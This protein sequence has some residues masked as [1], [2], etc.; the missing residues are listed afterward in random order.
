MDDNK[1]YWPERL[2][3]WLKCTDIKQ[4]QIGGLCQVKVKAAPECASWCSPLDRLVPASW[5]NVLHNLAVCFAIKLWCRHAQKL[6]LEA[7]CYVQITSL[8]FARWG[9]WESSALCIA[10][11][12]SL[13]M[14]QY[15]KILQDG[16]SGPELSSF[17]YALGQLKNVSAV[18]ITHSSWISISA[19]WQ[20]WQW[21]T[22]IIALHHK[23]FCHALLIAETLKIVSS[24]A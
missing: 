7:L 22:V 1:I 17:V 18:R 2:E 23:A 6:Q 3:S 5:N 20:T 19:V 24:R 8:D 9:V 4:Q 14:G 15:L 10:Q 13:S 16:D 12:G 21:I 11:N